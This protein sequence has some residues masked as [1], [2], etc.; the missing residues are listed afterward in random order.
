MPMRIQVL[1]HQKQ[2]N[3]LVCFYFIKLLKGSA[4]ESTLCAQERSMALPRTWPNTNTA[5]MIFNKCYKIETKAKNVKAIYT[6]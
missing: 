3:N 2:K 6:N 5:K 1:T 4:Y